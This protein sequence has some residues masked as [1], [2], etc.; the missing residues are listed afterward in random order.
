MWLRTEERYLN[1][2]KGTIKQLLWLYAQLLETQI[3]KDPNQTSG[4]EG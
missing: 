3:K 2:Q 1:Y 4:D